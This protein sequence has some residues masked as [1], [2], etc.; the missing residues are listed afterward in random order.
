MDDDGDGYVT[1]GELERWV[2][3][4]VEQGVVEQELMVETWRCGRSS[5]FLKGWLGQRARVAG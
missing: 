4:A 5:G 1:R 2:R 3:R